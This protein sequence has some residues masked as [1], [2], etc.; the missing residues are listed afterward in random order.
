[1]ARSL[2]R[3][4]GEAL[5]RST[6]RAAAVALVFTVFS[7]GSTGCASVTPKADP[8][9]VAYFASA[10]ADV[11]TTQQALDRG[12]VEV[13]PLLGSQ[14][15]TGKLVAVKAAGWFAMNSLENYLEKRMNRS[16]KWWEKAF[17]WAAPIG[18]QSWAAYH[19]SRVAR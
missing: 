15:S 14:P 17:V 6:N 16:L 18:I 13:N 4:L 19:N 8:V 10:T 2:A 3:A 5:A 11:V 7:L 9:H 12:A 1:M